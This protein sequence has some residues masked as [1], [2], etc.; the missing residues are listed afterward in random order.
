MA[1]TARPSDRG[2]LSEINTTPLIDV[3]LVLL[4]ML[5]ITVPISTHSLDVDLPTIGEDGPDLTKNS[6]VLRNDGRLEWNGRPVSD[7]QLA[8]QLL[9]VS[10]MSPEPEVRFE[11]EANASYQRSAQVM[12]IVKQSRISNFGFV[13]NE[14]YRTF[15]R[16]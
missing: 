10:R 11:P 15:D 5:I 14:R 7:A 13:G 6:L 12:L 1:V 16:R 2:P 3:L 9:L 8:G 4:V